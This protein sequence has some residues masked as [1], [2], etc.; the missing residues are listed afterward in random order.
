VL[1][2]EDVPA[3]ASLLRQYLEADEHPIEVVTSGEQALA[4]AAADPPAAICLD[5]ALS[6]EVDGWEV[7][8][9]LKASP[10][11]AN[12]PV[13]VCTGRNGKAHAAALGAADFLAKPFS[14][15][16]LRDAVA[17]ALPEQRGSVLVV[18]DEESVRR[19]VHE[20]LHG[21]G[22]EIREAADGEEAL[23]R[24]SEQKPDAV[25]L[26]L[27]MPGVDGFAVLEQ[28]QADAETRLLP[29]IVLT[30]KRL[31][32]DE[33]QRLLDRSVS[34]LQK[35]SYSASELRRLVRRALSE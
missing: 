6:G 25:I 10:A 4:R 19:L 22:Y 12:V 8:A 13:I 31:S 26:D 33:R 34:L 32:D 35:S 9:R 29:V 15:Q 28:L 3:A 27:I 16:E 5:V 14:Q 1:V 2:V 24:I 11:T 23:E 7:L 18:D 21:N 20:S 30:A 17:R